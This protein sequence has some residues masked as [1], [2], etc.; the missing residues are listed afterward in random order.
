MFIAFL[1]VFSL[2]VLLIPALSF[3]EWTPLIASTDFAGIHADVLTTAA[4]ILSI[5]LVIL[6]IGILVR[7]LG[8]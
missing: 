1:L 5:L 3:A 7:V 6:G 4:G 8:R 2:T